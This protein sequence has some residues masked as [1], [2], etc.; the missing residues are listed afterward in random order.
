MI[1]DNK[2]Y[3]IRL[4]KE[5]L[6]FELT[7]SNFKAHK[8]GDLAVYFYFRGRSMYI[9]YNYDKSRFELMHLNEFSNPKKTHKYHLQWHTNTIS[10]LVGKYMIN[11][12]DV[13]NMN[14]K[15]SKLDMLFDKIK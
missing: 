1:S 7:D 2:D 13:K 10:A 8:N 3:I 6:D 14:L 11:L 4:F 5:Y 12:H 15:K 9:F